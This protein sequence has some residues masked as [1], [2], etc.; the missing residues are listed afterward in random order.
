MSIFLIIPI[1]F[2]KMTFPAIKELVLLQISTNIKINE[3]EDAMRYN[4]SVTLFVK[5]LTNG[6]WNY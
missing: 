3:A 5:D 6:F 1:I 2:Y 4:W